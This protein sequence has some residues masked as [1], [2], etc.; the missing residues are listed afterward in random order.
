MD[1]IY[2][3]ARAEVCNARGKYKINLERCSE[4]CSNGVNKSLSRWSSGD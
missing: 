1:N 3:K 2:I 4:R